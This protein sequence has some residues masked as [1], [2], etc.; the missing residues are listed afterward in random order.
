M[1]ERRGER[2]SVGK[3]TKGQD[4]LGARERERKRESVV[5]NWT[6]AAERGRDRDRETTTPNLPLY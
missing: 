5:E 3:M 6:R 1:A 4:E 2:E